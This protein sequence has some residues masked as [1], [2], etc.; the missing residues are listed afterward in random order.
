MKTIIISGASSR[1]GKTTVTCALLSTLRQRGF[2][3]IAY[4]TGPDYID[5]EYLRR[6]GKCEGYN[7]DNWL[8]SDERML[9]LFTQTSSGKDIALIE[10]AMGLY[11]GGVNSTASIAKMIDA[12][13]VLVINARS[14]GE[15]AAAVALGLREYDRVKI[16]GV[17]LNFTGSEYHEKI[18]SSSLEEKGIKFFGALRR[19]DGLKIPERHL[20]LLTSQE[21]DGFDA[22][23]LR[24]KFESSVDVDSMLNVAEES[25]FFWPNSKQSYPEKVYNVKIGVAQDKAFTFCYPENLMMLER[26]GAEIVSFSPISDDSLP[27]ADGYIFVGGYPEVFADELS[28]NTAMIDSVRKIA[29]KKPILAECGGMMYLCRKINDFDMA[30]VIPF[31]AKM[32]ERPVMGYREAR[33]LRDNLLCSEGGVLRGHEYHYGRVDGESRPVF[34]VTRRDGSVLGLTGFA[35]ERMLASWLHVNFWGYPDV[36]ENFLKSTQNPS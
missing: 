36:A 21:N 1:S 28:E 32:S 33:A 27:D 15:S 31:D 35:G 20:G 7:L 26:F 17:I 30:G 6:C 3:V 25:K 23:R 16:A 10:G 18:I 4:K 2:N 11:D 34:E 24:V 29:G 5:T 19:D 22:E 9:E 14:M 13:V 12:P 8:M